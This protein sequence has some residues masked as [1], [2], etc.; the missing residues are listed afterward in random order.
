MIYEIQKFGITLEWTQ[1]LHEAEA[2]F[3]DTAP[4]SVVMYQLVGSKK[5]AIKVK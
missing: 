4:G 5:T 2:A 1:D 3:K